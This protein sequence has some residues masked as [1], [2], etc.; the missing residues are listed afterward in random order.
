MLIVDV[1]TTGLNPPPH[2]AVIAFAAVLADGSAIVDEYA[3]LVWCGRRY[4]QHSYASEAL[5]VNGIT[6]EMLIDA[7]TTAVVAADFWRWLAGRATEVT[8]FNTE[9]DA[10]YLRPAPWQF[11]LPRL[12]W[13]RCIMRWCAEVMGEAGVL[14]RWDSG[15]YKFPR[16]CDAARFFGVKH[17]RQHNALDDARTAAEIYIKLQNYK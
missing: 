1:E 4:L 3:S 5:R 15:S 14:P 7:P 17:E 10:C 11:T 12:E 2:D 9:F 6:I 8:A 13:A 16:L